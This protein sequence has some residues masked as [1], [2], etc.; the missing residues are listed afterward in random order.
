MRGAPL[1]I[2]NSLWERLAKKMQRAKL[3]TLLQQQKLPFIGRWL[4]KS[5]HKI[6][7]ISRL[8]DYYQ[9]DT[10]QLRVVVK[11]IISLWDSISV[12][13]ATFEL[14]NYSAGN[15]ITGSFTQMRQ[16]TTLPIFAVFGRRRYWH[17]YLG[18]KNVFQQKHRCMFNIFIIH[19]SLPS[20][21]ASQSTIPLGP[22]AVIQKRN[23]KTNTTALVP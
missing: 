22:Y 23:T 9:L 18:L 16:A 7:I 6:V 13:G 2:I 5:R 4:Q 11:H 3:Q 10:Q 19:N 12:L 14:Q 21:N 17:Y 20:S 8:R 15:L 1:L